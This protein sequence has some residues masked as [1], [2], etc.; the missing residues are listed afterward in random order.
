M[1][2]T[3]RPAGIELVTVYY[4]LMLSSAQ[5]YS[6]TQKA[7][8]TT[9]GDSKSG[10]SPDKKSRGSPLSKQVLKNKVKKFMFARQF[11]EES[12]SSSKESSPIKPISRNTSV[13]FS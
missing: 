13:T 7:E 4:W 6:I 10:S 12:T 8:P 2:S 9:K 11:T 1:K 5:F 3:C